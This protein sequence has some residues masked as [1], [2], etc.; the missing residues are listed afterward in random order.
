MYMLFANDEI[1]NIS[2][3]AEV[4]KLQIKSNKKQRKIWK[5][6]HDNKMIT[7][8]V[9]LLTMFCFLNCSLIYTFMNLLKNL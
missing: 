4:D 3:N 6:I 5:A 2:Y 8:L 9:V 1:L 7:M